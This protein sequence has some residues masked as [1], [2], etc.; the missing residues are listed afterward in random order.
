MDTKP[1]FKPEEAFE[2]ETCSPLPF[3]DNY[4]SERLTREEEACGKGQL[5]CPQI[6]L[7][8]ACCARWVAGGSQ[9]VSLRGIRTSY[10]E[11][12]RQCRGCKSEVPPTG[13]TAA[14]L[15]APEVCLPSLL[16]VKKRG[17][18]AGPVEQWLSAHVLLWQPGVRRFGSQMW[19][20]HHLAKAMLW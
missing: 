2:R 19:T 18:G 15:A 9:C 1:Q 8:E 12:P 5:T 6:T 10:V 13:R 7:G 3:L 20:W 14:C 11:R 4:S 16:G 17:R